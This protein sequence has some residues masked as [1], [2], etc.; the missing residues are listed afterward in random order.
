MRKQM[1]LAVAILAGIQ[2]SVALS[3]AAAQPIGC[4][5]EKAHCIC[6]SKSRCQWFYDCTQNQSAAAGIAYFY[7][8]M[9]RMDRGNA[10]PRPAPGARY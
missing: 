6:D 4:S 5:R 10:T 2:A 1:Y 7:P 9:M 8:Y 3:P